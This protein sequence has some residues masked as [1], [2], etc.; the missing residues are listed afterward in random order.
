MKY[1][2]YETCI[3]KSIMEVKM[4]LLLLVG[5]TYQQEVHDIVNN[6]IDIKQLQKQLRKR[7]D[8][9]L[10]I[11]TSIKK[12]LDEADTF[13]ILEDHLV[14]LNL[15]L[16]PL[17]PPV[18]KYKYNLFNYILDS[19]DFTVQS[20]CI[21]RH[22]LKFNENTI[23]D[24]IQYMCNKKQLTNEEYHYLASEIFCVEHLYG[25]AYQHL[26]YV[27]FDEHL[28]KYKFPLYQYS[29]YKFKRI[30]EPNKRGLL[31]VIFNR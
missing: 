24:F 29:P 30:I 16:D 2:S 17:F 31:Q 18:I 8:I 10:V 3:N 21:L 28:Q 22:L 13:S 12:A 7:T 1:K 14:Y 23:N 19:E 5:G 4:Y 26:P 27:S 11:F 15:L 9:S 6:S 20:Y 25:D